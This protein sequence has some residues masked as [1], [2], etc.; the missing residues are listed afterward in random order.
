[1]YVKDI[2]RTVRDLENW[3]RIWR[4]T[5]NA[6]NRNGGISVLAGAVLTAPKTLIYLPT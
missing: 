5:R 3:R 6:V 4:H 1:M 2:G